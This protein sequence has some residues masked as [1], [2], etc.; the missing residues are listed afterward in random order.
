MEKQATLIE[1]MSSAATETPVRWHAI[2]PLHVSKIY[3]IQRQ[4]YFV[5]K[6]F[7]K[8]ALYV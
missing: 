5:N 7:F 8:R 3:D 1:G 2:V 4:N 6:E